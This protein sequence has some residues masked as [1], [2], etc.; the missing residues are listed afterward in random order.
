MNDI[1]PK[2]WSIFTNSVF[3]L[4]SL[5][6]SVFSPQSHIGNQGELQQHGGMTEG[7]SF[8]CVQIQELLGE[9][10]LLKTCS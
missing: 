2:K 10:K 7:G 5:W 9:V 3:L 8:P 1:W 4:I 6:E